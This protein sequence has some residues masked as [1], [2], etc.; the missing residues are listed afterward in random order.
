MTFAA[1]NREWLEPYIVDMAQRVGLGFWH[2]RL[3]NHDPDPDA[4]ASVTI[5]G[6]NRMATIF[7]RDPNGDMED[8]RNSVIHELMHVHLHELEQ[9]TMGLEWHFGGAAWDVL[10]RTMHDR[11]EVTVC[12]LT[13]AW[14]VF[15]PLPAMPE[16]K[17]AA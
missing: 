13:R 9:V 12:A 17:E 15:L 6:D 14:E 3:S 1:D 4:T 7:L 8:L 2:I 10:S 5:I 11:L 16:A